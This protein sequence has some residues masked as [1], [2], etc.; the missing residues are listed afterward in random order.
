[1]SA[2]ESSTGNGFHNVA[3]SL[4]W[5]MIIEMHRAGIIIGSHT[6][7]HVSLPAES[8][9]TVVAELDGSK[10]AIERHIGAPV[11]HFAYPGGQFTPREVE[12]LERAGYR[13]GYTACPHQDSR[14]PTLTIERLLLWEG[15]SVDGD[16]QFSPPFFAVR[17]TICGRR[18]GP[19]P[20]STTYERTAHGL[21]ADYRSEGGPFWPAFLLVAGRTAGLIATFAIGPL[22][23]RLLTLEELGSYRTF[24]LLC[25][26]FFGLAQLG[27]AESLYYFVPRTP[28]Q[29]GRY[30]A[31]AALTLIVLRSCLPGAALAGADA[32]RRPLRQSRAAALP[33]AARRVPHADAGDDGV[34]DSDG[35]AQAAPE[36]RVDLRALR[37]HAH[38]VLRRPGAALRQPR[39][40]LHRRRWRL[41]RLRLVVMLLILRRAFGDLRPD[42][43]LWRTQ[44]AYALPFA[45]A[46]SVEVI[47]V[48][49]HQY[50]VGGTFDRATFAIYSTACMAI[51]LV[52]LIMTSTTSV[53]M[54]KMAE[55]SADRHLT[56]SLFHE[57][58]CA[59]GVSA[60]AA[61]HRPVGSRR[62]R[63]SWRCSRTS[64]RPAFPSS[65]C[66]R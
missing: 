18:R 53:M 42:L 32:D 31:N 8:M 17:F 57:T 66:G 29:A 3:L 49:Y 40:G 45:L 37:R 10:R 35:V 6:R 56:L 38:R 30:G 39:C 4:T 43:G 62:S 16:G 58:V 46:V 21:S 12:A 50:V 15:S 5:P 61:R 13:F 48:T 41:P 59:S 63:S 19:A 2:L 65:A 25:A 47:L 7:R 23:T 9:D 22:L 24:F 64:S 51:P 60:A 20:G 44:L 36:R 33:A 28:N 1:M 54:V 14:H 55:D 27:M 11:P 34:R 26:T 52:D